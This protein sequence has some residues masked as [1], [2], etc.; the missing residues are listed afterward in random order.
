MDQK[1]SMPKH[2]DVEVKDSG[3]VDAITLPPQQKTSR[4]MIFFSLYIALAGWI[5]NFDLGKECVRFPRSTRFISN[6]AKAT[7]ASS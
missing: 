3:N 6:I 7:V 5:Y 2:V 4:F 1:E